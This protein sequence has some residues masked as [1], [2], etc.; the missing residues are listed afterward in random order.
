MNMAS[1][2]AGAFFVCNSIVLKCVVLHL[3]RARRGVD[4]LAESQNG[5]TYSFT[6]FAYSFLPS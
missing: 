6:N 4:V 5:M 3:T 1:A 2:K